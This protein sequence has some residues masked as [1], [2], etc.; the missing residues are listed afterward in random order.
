MLS[1]GQKNN[2]FENEVR[3][4]ARAK[5]PF[6]Q[7]SGSMILDGRERDGVFETEETVHFIEAT[8]SRSAEKAKDDSKKIFRAIAE[9]N[10]KGGLKNGGG[11]FITKEEPTADQR[12]EVQEHGKGQV[13]AVSFSQFQ[14]SLI[15]VRAYL[16]C[17]KN[18]GFGSVQDFI[19][20]EKTPSVPFIEIGLTPRASEDGK[21]NTLF[22]NDVLTGAIT[23]EHYAITGQ[24]GA[25]KSMSL[26]EIFFRLEENYI[27]NRSSKFPVYINLREH[28]GQRDPIEILERHARSI[29][30]ESPSSLI[31]AWRAG[32]VVLLV[33]GFD[34]VTSLGVQG[35]WKKLKD[36]RMRS[37]EGIR[38]LHRES[39]GIGIIACGRSHYFE[40]DNE[41]CNALGLFNA[42]VLSVDE[43]TDEQMKNFLS[44]FPSSNQNNGFPDWL[45]TRPLLLGYL[46]SKGLLSELGEKT[47]LPDAVDGWDYLLEKIYQR[48]GLIETNLDGATLRRILE[49]TATLARSTED[50]LGPIT[51]TDLFSVF[52]EVCGYEPDEQGVLAIQRLPGLGIYRAEDESRCFVDSELAD[53][54]KGHELLRFLEDPYDSVKESVWVGAM[55]SCDRPVG[56]IATNLAV[57]RLKMG[58]DARGIIRQSAAFLNSREDLACVRGDVAVILLSSDIELDIDFSVSEINFAGVLLEFHRNMQN[59][60]R[61]QLSHC[62]FENILIES[63][64]DPEILPYFDYCLIDHISGRISSKDLPNNKFMPSCEFGEFDSAQT[65]T[66]IR[67]VQ[68]STGEKV[69]LV[70]LRKLFV[71]SLSGRAENALY[72]GLDVD[73]RRCVPDILKLL[74]RKGLA[75]DHTR[76][77]GV[78]WLPVRKA[79]QRVKRILS[80]PNES[81]EDVVREARSLS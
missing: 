44:R 28:S 19:S 57:R 18:H 6:A 2:D 68:I 46:A 77:D 9:H 35:S 37:L 29:G 48:E 62:L 63:D 42:K 40:N 39:I 49:R 30:F 12:K 45:P 22:V 61:L 79:M 54:C 1:E 25:G 81:G 15:D 34:E 5:W 21:I 70:T 24:Y 69:L 11:W 52:T 38:K 27:K 67:A 7:Y 60:S 50:G 80:T 3:R 43:F 64:I 73:E 8:V 36:L 41:L 32:F 47:A 75:I 59:L 17:R 20:G 71:Q 58:A 26:R 76:G 51:R 16:A 4:I 14:Q 66:A 53:V 72:R 56:E 65:G 13:K 10:K 74:K 33:D 78:I 23:G 31:R 55:N